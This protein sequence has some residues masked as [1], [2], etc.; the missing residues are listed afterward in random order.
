MEYRERASSGRAGQ[1]FPACGV[2]QP[3]GAEAAG[4]ILQR[5]ALCG[6]AVFAAIGSGEIRRGDASVSGRG[7]GSGAGSERA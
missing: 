7:S 3:D 6:R 2:D 4:E 1:E 5:Q